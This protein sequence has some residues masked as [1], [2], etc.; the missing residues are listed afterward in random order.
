[1]E[2]RVQEL[3]VKQEYEE[4]VKAKAAAEIEVAKKERNQ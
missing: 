4:G 1:M 2:D 3:K